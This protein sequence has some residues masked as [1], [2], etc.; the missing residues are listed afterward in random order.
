MTIEHLILREGKL[1]GGVPPNTRGGRRYY[2]NILDI[3]PLDHETRRR[4]IREERAAP[5]LLK[6]P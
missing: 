6:T 2:F 5:L 1:P 4:L 3:M